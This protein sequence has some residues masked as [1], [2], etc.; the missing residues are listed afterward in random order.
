MPLQRHTRKIDMHNDE[1]KSLKDPECLWITKNV[2]VLNIILG[3]HAF[4]SEQRAIKQKD[5]LAGAGS[6]SKEGAI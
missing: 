4:I 6:E 3:V 1:Y 2:I 5:L